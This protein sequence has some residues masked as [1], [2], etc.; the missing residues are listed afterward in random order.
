MKN[1]LLVDYL[2]LSCSFLFKLL[3]TLI[4]LSCGGFSSC[5]L[6]MLLSDAKKSVAQHSVLHLSRF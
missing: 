2:I 3:I 1:F 5:Y 6:K 4:L